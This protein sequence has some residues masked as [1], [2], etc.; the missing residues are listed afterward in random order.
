LHLNEQ[1]LDVLCDK[2]MLALMAL[3]VEKHWTE[4]ALD[5]MTERDWRIFREDFNISY[6]GSSHTVLPMR[7]W[8]EANFPE[9]IMKASGAAV[10]LKCSLGGARVPLYTLSAARVGQGCCFARLLVH[11]PPRQSTTHPPAARMPIK[12]LILSEAARRPAGRQAGRRCGTR[13]PSPPCRRSHS[14]PPAC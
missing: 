2:A 4:K 14:V 11:D 5:E 6:K 7:N 9:P 10:H 12:N 8:K 1:Y 3:Q 13:C